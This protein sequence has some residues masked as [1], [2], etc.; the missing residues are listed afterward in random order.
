MCVEK[1]QSQ[2]LDEV[3]P[4]DSALNNNIKEHAQQTIIDCQNNRAS[5]QNKIL[6]IE[7]KNHTKNP[8]IVS[9]NKNSVSLD[10]PSHDSANSSSNMARHSVPNILGS[11]DDPATAQTLSQNNHNIPN[12]VGHVAILSHEHDN[13]IVSKETN[14]KFENVM[15]NLNSATSHNNPSSDNGMDANKN[16][17]GVYP[18]QDPADASTKKWEKIVGSRN[19]VVVSITKH[20]YQIVRIMFPL[21]L[22]WPTP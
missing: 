3:K 2:G 17:T 1:D 4:E 9:S 18:K 12:N 22:P 11:K 10:E 20:F 16:D 6:E 7:T 5:S 14:L 8:A 21:S 19:K 13:V 15:P